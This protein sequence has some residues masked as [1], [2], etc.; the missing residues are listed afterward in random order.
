M[1]TTTA[2]PQGVRARARAETMAQILELGR[3]QLA[4]RGA[5]DLSVRAIARDLG[6]VSSGIYRYVASRDDLLTALI[7][8]AYDQLGAVVEDAATARTTPGRRFLRACSATRLW[9][10]AHPHD[11]ALIFGSPV[12][13]YQ[14]P[15]DTI[16]AATRVPAVLLGLAAQQDRDGGL[17]EHGPTP[18]VSRRLSTQAGRVRDALATDLPDA[19]VVRCLAAWAM[20]NGIISFELFGQLAN[21]FD[22][23]D[24][25]AAHVFTQAALLV[26]FPD[27]D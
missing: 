12:P 21:T 17:L 20:V 19:A 3:E 18:R 4:E 8:D 1:T 27:V 9:A 23:A 22:P 7:I 10:V 25:A 16:A 11:W 5:A 24:D 26:G 13:G 14:A 15:A 2:A 6:M